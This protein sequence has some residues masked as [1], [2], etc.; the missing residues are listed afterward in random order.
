MTNEEKVLRAIHRLP[1]LTDGEL[2]E[3]TGV[4]PHQQVNQIC[5][6]LA[7]RGR[8]ERRLGPVG[9]I[10]NTPA[11]SAGDPAPTGATTTPQSAP[12]D[13]PARP[14]T[15]DDGVPW[16]SLP[17]AEDALIVIPCSAAK[18]AGG[19]ASP[20]GPHLTDELPAG[21]ADRLRT[22]RR[23]VAE[24]AGV[25]ESHLLPAVD[26]YAGTLYKRAGA[27]LLH[28]AAGRSV[29][30]SGGYG[31]VLPTESIGQ[32]NRRFFLSDWPNNLIADA[33]RSLA[34]ARRARAVVAFMGFSTSYA[35]LVRRY[36]WKAAGVPAY[37]VFPRLWRGGGAQRRVPQ[38]L[39]AILEAYLRGTP[40]PKHEDHAYSLK[41]EAMG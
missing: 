7:R 41:I 31:L 36:D 29:I 6:R 9:L 20:V 1:G 10:V 2:V 21:L 17:P 12:P 13:E 37:L 23:A 16:G 30:V 27:E 19:T 34:G 22:A 24:L 4:R 3:R 8:I 32:Y 14:P 35:E 33:I 25:D 15:S 5:R 11:V 40:P 39:G 28:E 26:R 18:H 38:L